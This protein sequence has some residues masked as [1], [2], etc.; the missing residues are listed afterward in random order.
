MP[1]AESPG[2]Q[3]PV[4]AARDLA[5]EDWKAKF[6]AIRVKKDGVTPC[7]GEISRVAALKPRVPFETLRRRFEKGQTGLLKSG[8]APALGELEGALKQWLCDYKSLGVNLY[9]KKVRQKAV[10]LAVAAGIK[11]DFKASKN[12][13]DAFLRRN[14]LKLLAGQFMEAVRRHAVSKEALNRFFDLFEIASEGV[15]AKHIYMLDEVHVN[16]LETGSYK[17]RV[18][19][20][21]LPSCCTLP[22]TYTISI[23]YRWWCLT[24]TR[25]RTS[26]PQ[27]SA[28][29]LA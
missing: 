9:E 15:E 8:A 4:F 2:D 18:I 27:K 16:L 5:V 6:A 22:L 24:A 29:T 12:W 1:D 25:L 3:G 21:S 17:V 19:C 14:G 28:S 7:Y 23:I 10:E 13:L 20:T 11:W 26:Q